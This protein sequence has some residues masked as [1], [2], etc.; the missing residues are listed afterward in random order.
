[1]TTSLSSLRRFTDIAVVTGGVALA[2]PVCGVFLFAVVAAYGAVF[3]AALFGVVEWVAFDLNPPSGATSISTACVG[4]VVSRVATGLFEP[5]TGLSVLRVV[6]N[7][8]MALGTCVGVALAIATPFRI[9]AAFL[10]E[11]PRPA[12][13]DNGKPVEEEAESVVTLSIN[14]T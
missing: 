13:D 6:C 8:L 14:M 1:M 11:A 10:R 3:G 4:W 7:S 12:Q 5:W 2:L 9:V